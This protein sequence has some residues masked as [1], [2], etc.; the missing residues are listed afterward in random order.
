MEVHH[1]VE[2]RRKFETLRRPYGFNYVHFLLIHLYGGSPVSA[3]LI[4][5]YP[6][7]ATFLRLQRKL[8]LHEHEQDNQQ[9]ILE[10]LILILSQDNA[11]LTETVE[12]A[13]LNVHIYPISC[14]FRLYSP[15]HL[16]L[17]VEPLLVLSNDRFNEI[18]K[19]TFDKEYWKDKCDYI[20]FSI[21]H[22]KTKLLIGF[23]S[24]SSQQNSNE[25]NWLIAKINAPSDRSW[26]PIHYVSM[27]PNLHD[28][29]SRVSDAAES[30]LFTTSR[31]TASSDDAKRS[32]PKGSMS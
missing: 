31:E 25:D 22:G 19:R 28:D 13:Y 23:L 8:N 27:G 7:Y 17:F 18:V 10:A 20:H 11:P 4:K 12:Q 15:L 26:L 30:K 5:T 29:A 6:L 1:W 21:A 9:S 24:D 14:L 16:I 32:I 2:L 3:A